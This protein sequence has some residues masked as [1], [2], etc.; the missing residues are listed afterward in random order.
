M[1]GSFSAGADPGAGGLL[2]SGDCAAS[3]AVAIRRALTRKRR[4][5]VKALTTKSRS[6]RSFVSLKDGRLVM[7]R[8]FV[9]FVS[10]WFNVWLISPAQRSARHAGPREGISP[11]PP[12]RRTAK[13]HDTARDLH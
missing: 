13:S 4:F 7:R 5:I 6:P 2:R 11:R 1:A 3:V 9:P 10:S 12:S 8:Y